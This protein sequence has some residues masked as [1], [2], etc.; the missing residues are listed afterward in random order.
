MK[1][2]IKSERKKERNLKK[3]KLLKNLF[4]YKVDDITFWN[5]EGRYRCLVIFMN[6]IITAHNNICRMVLLLDT[7]FLYG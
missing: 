4:I 5:F 3:T 7:C 2:K 6:F 1:L